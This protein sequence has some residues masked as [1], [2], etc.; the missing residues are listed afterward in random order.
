MPN[1]DFDIDS[2]AAYLHLSPQQVMRMA[3]RGKLP[4]RKLGGQ[5]RFAEAEIHHWLEERIGVSDDVELSQ[6]EGVLARSDR[7]NVDQVA[8]IHELLQP[9][10]IEIPLPARTRNSVIEQMS[11]LAESTGLLW[12][13]DR[14]AEAL[15]AREELHPTALGNGIALLHPRRPQAAILA[16]AFLAFGRTS[17]G[18]PFGGGRGGLTQVFFLICST[19][20]REHLRILARL[21]RLLT[22]ASV[23]A[24]L[25]DAEDATEVRQMIADAE[26][27]FEN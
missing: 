18:I 14:M 27:R 26:G 15:R 25:H 21:S 11:R 22:D 6:V 12:D 16:E 1:N 5:W 2:L 17:Q 7:G 4:G 9:A 10:A 13:A 20:D 3:D 24:A 8:A 19:N 23:V